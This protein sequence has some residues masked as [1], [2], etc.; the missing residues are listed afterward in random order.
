MSDE[1]ERKGV[2]LKLEV[3]LGRERLIP[4]EDGYLI[5]QERIGSEQFGLRCSIPKREKLM[6]LCF[7][8]DGK[9]NI[10]L[11]KLRSEDE[12]FSVFSKKISITKTNFN[13]LITRYPENNLRILFPEEKGRFEIWEVAIVSQD[14]LF[15]LTTQMAYE[16]KC[17]KEKD[18]KVIC[19]RFEW[20]TK[21]PQLIEI[22]KSIFERE[23][24]PPISEY[25]APSLSK[26]E[27]LQKNQGV[28]VW[29]NLAQGMGAIVLD[30]KGTLARVHWK[31][32]LPDPKRRLKSLLPGQ[33]ISYRKLDQARGRTGF[34]LE[35]KKVSPLERE[36]KNANC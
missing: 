21:W 26:A 13:I 23:E 7:S 31:G 19:P 14:G 22:I 8:V 9:K 24:L 5:S 15:F 27:G 18:G 6:P 36:E 29:W 25:V 4:E 3:I 17:F 11:M 30:E 10:T 12:C 35:A 16:A 28:V 20:E 1:L 33:I 34:L 2:K 32:I